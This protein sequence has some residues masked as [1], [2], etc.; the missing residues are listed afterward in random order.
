MIQVYNQEKSAEKFDAKKEETALS[1]MA[2]RYAGQCIYELRDKA[3]IVDQ[4]Y[5]FF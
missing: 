3:E 1:N 2:A 4:R 5:L